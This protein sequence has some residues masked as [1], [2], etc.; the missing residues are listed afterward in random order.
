MIRT[1]CRDIDPLQLGLTYSHE[2]LISSPPEWKAREDPDLVIVDLDKAIEEVGQFAH[3]GGES[4]FEASA[5]DYGRDVRALAKISETCH[6]NI[7]ACAGF[8]KGMWFE[9][10]IE[11]WS[12]S[13]LIDHIVSEVLD[14]IDGTTIKGGCIKFGTGYNSISPAEERVIRAA[15]KAH[16]ITG[17]PLHGHTEVGTMAREQIEILAEEGVDM[18]HVAFCHVARN[19][20]NWYLRK[21]AQSGAFLCFDGLSKVKYYT[22]E[23]RIDAILRLCEQGYAQQI[24]LG[25]DMARQTDLH[26]YTGGPGLQFILGKWVPRFREELSERGSS[27]AQIQGTVDSFLVQNPRRYF[28]M[29]ESY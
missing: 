29:C 22:E 25:G 15:A 9:P 20:D 18:A 3:L 16:R 11:G 12:Y 10:M 2:H 5:Y 23:T 24:L 4:L 21:I 27:T 28:D 7:I 14:G 17:A 6:V 19:P 8:N 13:K 26:A 1:V